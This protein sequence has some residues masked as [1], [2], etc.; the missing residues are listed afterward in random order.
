MRHARLISDYLTDEELAALYA[1]ACA[2][3]HPSLLEGFGFPVV[4]AQKLG[5]P[6]LVSDLP[7]AHDVAGEGAL[8]FPTSDVT[9]LASA[10]A[11]IATDADLRTELIRR[12]KGNV[13][14][15]D[16]KISAREVVKSYSRI[17]QPE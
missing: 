12:G 5:T 13:A 2:L 3:V 4:E 1:G 16:W 11:R 8:Y 17:L 15:F 9:A 6:V 7:W 10:L 14:R